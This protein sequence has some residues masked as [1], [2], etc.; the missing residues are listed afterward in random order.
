MR[1]G[2]EMIFG[3]QQSSYGSQTRKLT[4]GNNSN[5]DESTKFWFSRAKRTL[6]WILRHFCISNV[7]VSRADALVLGHSQQGHFLLTQN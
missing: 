4:S 5:S 2:T 7:G 6:R 1:E 3:G